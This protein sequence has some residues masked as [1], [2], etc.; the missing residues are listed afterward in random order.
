MTE[1]RKKEIEDMVNHPPHYTSG[2]IECI[3][4]ME[5]CSTREQFEGYLKNAVIKYL[6]RFEKKEDRLNDLEKARWYL[7][8]LI[9]LEE[10]YV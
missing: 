8:K 7:N 10:K 6:W 3:D 4:A 5:A 1:Q 2:D 9:K